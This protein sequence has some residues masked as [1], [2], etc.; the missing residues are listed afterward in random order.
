MRRH[1]ETPHE[2][3]A[4]LRSAERKHATTVAN[5]ERPEHSELHLRPCLPRN[6]FEGTTA[7]IRPE[8]D[9]DSTGATDAG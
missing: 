3:A 8:I 1:F 5:L 6:G 7:E 2:Q 9:Q 4:L